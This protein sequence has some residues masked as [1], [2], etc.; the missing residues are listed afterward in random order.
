MTAQRIR[1]IVAQI[2][3]QSPYWRLVRSGNTGPLPLAQRFWIALS[4]HAFGWHLAISYADT[5]TPLPPGLTEEAILRAYRFRRDPHRRDVHVALA[6]DITL[7]INQGQRDLLRALLLCNATFHEIAQ[8][9][10]LN[11]EL[12]MLFEALFWNCRDRLSERVYL[13]RICN[14][15]VFARTSGNADGTIDPVRVAY[16]S[17]RV[18]DV[19]AEIEAHPCA[20]AE[21]YQ[22]VGHQLLARAAMGLKLDRVAASENPA[23]I[24]ALR[25][26]AQMKRAAQPEKRLVSG[27]DA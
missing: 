5:G 17:G 19:L 1:E 25:L 21:G 11:E 2:G 14:Q 18:E 9:C 23:L 8:Q 13:A 20:P 15:G 4:D 27:P 26:I 24:P 22:F 12:V 16:G 3:P 10:G 6:Y 7:P